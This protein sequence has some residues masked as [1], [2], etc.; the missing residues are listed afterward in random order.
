MQTI[1]NNE[2]SGET[3]SIPPKS[4]SLR[5]RIR[6]APIAITSP[7]A[8]TNRQAEAARFTVRLMESTSS[9]VNTTTASGEASLRSVRYDIVNR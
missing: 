2:V 9:A 7:N 6:T 1:L 8:A 4:L 3:T 5:G